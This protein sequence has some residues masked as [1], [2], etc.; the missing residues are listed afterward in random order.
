MEQDHIEESEE[1]EDHYA[2]Y[3]ESE[4]EI[5]FNQQGI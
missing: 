3:V 4:L 2:Y 5:L 1:S